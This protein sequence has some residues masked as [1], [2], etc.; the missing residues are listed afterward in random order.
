MSAISIQETLM[1]K[2]LEE[3]IAYQTPYVRCIDPVFKE[4]FDPIAARRMSKIIKRAIITAKKAIEESGIEQPDAIITG[5]GLG[6]IEDTEK[7]L[8][9]MIR[10]EEKFLQPTNFIQSTHNTISSQIAIYQHCN[11]YNNTYIHRGVSFENALMDAVL[12]FSKNLIKTALVTGND[13][14]TPAYSV[15]L[16][17]IGYWKKEVDNTLEIIKKQDGSGSFAGEGSISL[18]LSKEKSKS[19]YSA[20][21]AMDLFYKPDSVNEKFQ[22][23]LS[24]NNMEIKDIDVIM[25]GMN[26]DVEN[27]KI[28]KQFIE[29]LSVKPKVAVYKHIC[30]EFYTS[31]AFG[32]YAAA[33]CIKKQ[34][35]PSLLMTD[36][37]SFFRPKNILLYNHFQNKDH[38]FILVSNV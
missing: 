27:D 2:S 30:G 1:R 21:K 18:M 25:C 35:I 33:E 23:F 15:L 20:I 31:N 32:L 6:C 19:T 17:R 34:E 36:D 8:D 38:S 12:L 4:Y 16:G 37:N 28:Y 14:M 26:G 9:S 29:N 11:G 5:T 24:E 13:E 3:A 22:Q 10:N 7:F